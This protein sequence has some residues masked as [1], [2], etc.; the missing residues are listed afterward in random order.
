VQ[1]VA[2]RPYASLRDFWE[3]AGVSRPVTERLALVGGFDSLYARGG[4]SRRDL[5]ARVGGLYRRAGLRATP[6]QRPFDLGAEGDGLGELAPAG[7]LRELTPPERVGTELDVLGIDLSQH[8]LSFYAGLMA[9]L[10]VVRS[11]DLHRCRPGAQVL[12]AGVKVA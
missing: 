8:V 2:G 7:E 10:G 6:R 3:R 5:L 12:V 4:V 9:E 11:V 1:I